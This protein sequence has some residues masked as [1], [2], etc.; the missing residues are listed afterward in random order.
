MLWCY[1]LCVAPSFGSNFWSHTVFGS[2]TLT[3]H[4]E[5][6]EILVV[7]ISHHIFDATKQKHFLCF[8]SL[9]FAKLTGC[10]LWPSIQI[11]MK[12]PPFPSD[13]KKMT[14]VLLFKSLR[15]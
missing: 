4:Q 13:G 14:K 12:I 2:L 15:S 6:E 1:A 10:W 11:Q 5:V 3:R 7:K 8:V 9:C